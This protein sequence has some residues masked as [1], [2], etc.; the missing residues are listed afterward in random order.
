MLAPE[1]MMMTT[2]LMATLDVLSS[3]VRCCSG[4][5]AGPPRDMVAGY[6]AA[7][8]VYGMMDAEGGWPAALLSQQVTGVW[9]DMAR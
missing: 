9:K 2:A 1:S 5:S 7:L 3:G 4:A 8:R 6:S